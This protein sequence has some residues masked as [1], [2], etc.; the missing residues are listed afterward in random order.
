MK[1]RL[2]S[3]VIASVLAFGAL[4]APAAV[5]L[6]PWTCAIMAAHTQTEDACCVE[7]P[8]EPDC[9]A[10]NPA[11][12]RTDSASCESQHAPSHCAKGAQHTQ[13]CG[14]SSGHNGD[15]LLIVPATQTQTQQVFSAVMAVVALDS[16]AHHG[17]QR[18][19]GPQAIPFLPHTS[20]CVLN[21]SFLC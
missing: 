6:C 21:Q 12:Q 9:C 18:L 5:T 13:A 2:V 14:C 3:I 4:A 15:P 8:A 11:S 10:S 17:M 7:K 1:T 19:L 20:F 16:D